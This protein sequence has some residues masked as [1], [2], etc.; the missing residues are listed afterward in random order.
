M[1][2]YSNAPI[3]GKVGI[4]TGGRSGHEPAFNGYIGKNLVDSVAVGEL[5]SSPT[6]KSFLDTIRAADG[7]KGVAMLYGN[8]AG[9]NMNVKMAMED[10]L[11]EG[12]VA[13]TVVANGDV[14][15][16]PVDKKEK[17]RG[18]AGEIFMWKSAVAKATLGGRQTKL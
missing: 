18:V 11:D 1:V 13:R 4:V 8:Y 17:R 9:D 5:F 16:A 14:P 6:E 3:T 15:S 12:I 10:A 2:N 7:G